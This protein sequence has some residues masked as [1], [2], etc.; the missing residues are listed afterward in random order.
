MQ[1]RDIAI[2]LAREAGAIIRTNFTRGMTKQWKEDSSPVTAT[3]MAINALVLE[4]L[5]AHDPDAA[6]LAEEGSLPRAGASRTWVCDPVDGTIPFSHGIPTCAFSLALVEDGTPILGVVFDPFLDRLFVAER[7]T[8]TT[9]NG[10]PVR[11]S[12][13]ASFEHTLLYASSSIHGT[14]DY[15]PVA[16]ELRHRGA[17]IINFY[18]LV[19]AG[20][21]I[22]AGEVV[23]LVAPAT[24]P[25]DAA[26]LKI[27]IEEAGGRTSDIEGNDQ[28][29][30]T[31]LNGFLATNGAL[32]DDILTLL[33]RV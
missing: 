8:G 10:E 23:A 20:M 16:R 12:P 5:H 2:A 6:I 31:D 15:F 21:L 24:K 11:V 33:G 18:S 7:G 19:Y 22:A 30:D 17:R 9:C 28:R 14:K 3:D 26:A 13:T 32:H 29:Y 25:W 27:L 4:R 1:H